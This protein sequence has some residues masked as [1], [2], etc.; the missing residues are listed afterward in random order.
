MASVLRKLNLVIWKNLIIRKR[1]WILT[2]LEIVIPTLLFVLCAAVRSNISESESNEKPES[3]FPVWTEENLAKPNGQLYQD[4]VFLYAPNNSFGKEMVTEVAKALERK[5]IIGFETEE[6]LIGYYSAL[7]DTDTYAIVFENLPK[8]GPPDHLQYKIRLSRFSISTSQIFNEFQL[9]GPGYSE[10]DL[11][12]L[13]SDNLTLQQFP[14]PAY[15]EENFVDTFSYILPLFT[16]LSYILLCPTIARVVEEK[17]SGVKELMKM[18]G[19]K[20]WMLWI[21]WLINGLLVCFVSVTV[22]TILLKV[23][24]GTVG[25]LHYCNP[26]VLWLFLM[27]YCAAGITFC[28]AV[29]SFFSRP[30]LAMC[31]GIVL[32]LLSYAMT[33]SFIL[34]TGYVPVGVKILSALLPNTAIGWAYRLIIAYESKYVSVTWSNLFTPPSGMKGDLSIGI[35]W[36]MLI[37]DMI[38]YSIITWYIDCIK[39]GQYGI[40]RP[41][42]FIFQPSYWRRGRVDDLT[43]SDVD[44]ATL[45]KK[46][47]KPPANHT[48]GIKIQNLRKVFQSIGGLNKK[49]AVDGVTLDIYNGE[50]TALLGHNGAGKTTTMSILTGLFSATSGSVYIDG[51]DIHTQLEKVRESLGLCPQHNLLFTELTVMEHLIFFAMV[52]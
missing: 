43:F 12:E 1:H 8:T 7:N 2:I 29:S 14:Y 46:F 32:W 37:V 15:V 21:G 5:D 28:F 33:I 20:T 25:V 31:G 16:V 4:N 35:L 41:W 9:K 23:P 19:L 22:I 3:Y 13:S 48:V 27:F 11:K 24:F 10:S 47:E 50:I 34:D 26:I 36:I 6:D 18:M 30:I 45:S 39:P 51:Y 49:I 38:L 42:Y 52:I 40:A 44:E 17:Q